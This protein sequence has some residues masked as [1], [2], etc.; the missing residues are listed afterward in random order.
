MTAAML[1]TYP[2]VFAGGAVI[3]GLPFG[4]ATTVPEAFERMRGQAPLGAGQLTRLV[5]SASHHAGRWP[6]LS[7][8]HGSSDH[9]VDASNADALVDQWRGL[10]GVATDPTASETIAGHLRRVWCNADGLEVIEE[11]VIAN[12]GHGTPIHATPRNLGEAAGP[13]MLDV[14]ISSTRRIV[15]FWKLD[16]ETTT[17]RATPPSSN[18][19]KTEISS[20]LTPKHSPSTPS[21]LETGS[22][23]Q[24]VIEKAL[25]GAGLMS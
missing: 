15:A 8:W 10:H 7:V 14:G 1:A 2:D 12:M 9:T 17:T 19:R 3:A 24:E 4:T 23:V 18:P 25:R 11:Y 20:R 16:R 22:R 13:Y 21:T 6:T 5:R